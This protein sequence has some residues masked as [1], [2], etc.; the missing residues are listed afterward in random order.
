MK[1][2]YGNVYVNIFV[3]ELVVSNGGCIRWGGAVG[4]AAGGQWGDV[5]MLSV[6]HEMGF[7]IVWG[8]Q[9]N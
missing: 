9:V 7:C 8:D 6:S 4:G 2:I 5:I 1:A 3:G